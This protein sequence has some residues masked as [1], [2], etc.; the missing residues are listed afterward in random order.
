MEH[1]QMNSNGFRWRVPLLA[2]VA[3]V[4]VWGCGGSK[5]ERA[6][7]DDIGE[8]PADQWEATH[9]TVDPDAKPGFGR[10]PFTVK[11]TAETKN[12]KGKVTY[13]WTFG[14]GTD[15]SAD[16]APTHTFVKPGLFNIHVT[17]KDESGEEDWANVSVRALTEQEAQDMQKQYDDRGVDYKV[18]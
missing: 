1:I 9:F 17:A 14:D 15:P 12:A 8:T 18:P 10:V 4:A 6:E 13:G 5:Q 11:C 16:P 7:T 2:V 3:L